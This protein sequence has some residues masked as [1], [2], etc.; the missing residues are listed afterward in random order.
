MKKVIIFCLVVLT[1]VLLYILLSPLRVID[2]RLSI[3]VQSIVYSLFTY[4]SL[5]KRKDYS[6]VL[7]VTAIFLGV[8]AIDFPLRILNW[9]GSL[10]SILPTICSMAGI[11]IAYLYY[12]YRLKSVLVIF[13]L[14]GLY[15]ISYGQWQ[16]SNYISYG[17]I[18]PYVHISNGIG[19][20]IVYTSMNDSTR[21]KDLEHKYIVL[22]FWNSSCGHC[23]KAFPIFQKLYDQYKQRND[24]FIGSVFVK[25][26]KNETYDTGDSI[27]TKKNYTFPTFATEPKSAFFQKSGVRVFPTILI[28]NEKRDIIY[29]GNLDSARDKL[30]DILHD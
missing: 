22:D 14:I 9:K 6:A 21:L 27:L 13:A 12:Q 17:H 19:D 7:V 11:L 23:Y 5:R 15:C 18:S 8:C 30:E 10:F 4:L 2:I 25:R 16:L 26:K 29:Q 1:S 28:L 20:A 24:V 3:A